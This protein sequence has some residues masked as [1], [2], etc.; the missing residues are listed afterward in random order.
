MAHPRCVGWGEIG[1]DYHYDHSPRD[2]QQRVFTRQLRAAVRLGKPLTIHT[3][4]AEDDTERI[5]KQEVPLDHKVRRRRVVWGLVAD[6]P[7]SRFTCIASQTRPSLRG[8]SSLTFQ[9]STS[10]SRASSR[11]RA[12]S[13]LPRSCVT[14]LALGPT[15][16]GAPTHNVM[17]RWTALWLW[18]HGPVTPRRS[19]A[20]ASSSR[21]TPR[22]WCPPTSTRLSP[23]SKAAFRSATRP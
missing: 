21:R 4:E 7:T 18:A 19:A 6:T 5:L 10:A 1:L 3:R 14:W 22:S 11:T 20:R 9:T 15:R 13:T 17:L 23:R 16:P 2:V 8:A 12:I